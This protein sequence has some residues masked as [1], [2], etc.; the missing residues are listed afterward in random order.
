MAAAIDFRA[1]LPGGSEAAFQYPAKLA[2][3]GGA[4]LAKMWGT[5]VLEPASMR[6]F[7][8]NVRLPTTNSTEVGMLTD[9]LLTQYNTYVVC[10]GDGETTA[11]HSSSRA[12]YWMRISSQIYLDHADFEWLGNAVL[13]ILRTLRQH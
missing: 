8:T 9:I 6:G 4:K 11:S 13:D 2:D 1:A 3:A 10:E 5:D 7:L 12:R